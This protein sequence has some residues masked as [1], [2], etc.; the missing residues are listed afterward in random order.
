MLLLLQWSVPRSRVTRSR[1]G[2]ATGKYTY[3]WPVIIVSRS[4]W[5]WGGA[6]CRVGLRIELSHEVLGV[7][8]LQ[9]SMWRIGLLGRLQ[10]VV[11]AG[12][13]FW[14]GLFE[15]SWRWFQWWLGF[16]IWECLE[17]KIIIIIIFLTL[18]SLLS[19]YLGLRSKL[20]RK[21]VVISRNEWMWI[22]FITWQ[23]PVSPHLIISLSL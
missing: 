17:S 1:A 21:R 5:K 12:M 4:R 23:A 7:D 13:G 16:W 2:R 22:R 9:I 14:L 11:V 10:V 20:S 18:M 19:F 15:M 3:D 6:I 8:W